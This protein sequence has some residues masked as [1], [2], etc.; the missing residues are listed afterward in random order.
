MR[1]FWISL[2]APLHQFLALSWESFQEIRRGVSKRSLLIHWKRWNE[3]YLQQIKSDS[4]MIEAKCRGIGARK[5]NQRAVASL[6]I[7]LIAGLVLFPGAAL[8]GS[9]AGES[10]AIESNVTATQIA[11]TPNTAAPNA[12]VL[13]E[14]NCAAC[15]GGGGNIV[16][17][18]KNLK[19]KALKRYGMDSQAAIANIITNGK[20]I[21]SAYGEA[22]EYGAPTRLTTAEI[23]A[24][25]D[26]VLAQAALD[27]K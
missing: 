14:Q 20:G 26:Y 27:W 10:N 17:R 9:I 8:A 6:L 18:G 1:R 23:D 24:L 22:A 16:R 3:R 21:M 12:S 15:H 7:L 5:G 11:A 2:L 4:A 19:V 13:F 25:A